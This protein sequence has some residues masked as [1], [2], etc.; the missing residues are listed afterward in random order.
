MR[1]VGHD[2]RD[3]PV[4]GV[5]A[6]HADKVRDNVAAG[7]LP[8]VLASAGVEDWDAE[9]ARGNRDILEIVLEVANGLCKVRAVEGCRDGKEAV[10]EAHLAVGVGNAGLVK[11]SG[12]LEL[13]ELEVETVER[14]GRASDDKVACAVHQGNSDVPVFRQVLVGGVDVLLNGLAGQITEGK[15]RSGST[16]ALVDR[17]LQDIGREGSARV[18]LLA[19]KT[20]PE[21]D[22]ERVSR[23]LVESLK[24]LGSGNGSCGD[25][26]L[27]VT[28]GTREALPDVAG[29][30]AQHSAHDEVVC[31]LGQTNEWETHWG[32][33]QVFGVWLRI[34]VV[35]PAHNIEALGVKLLSLG[36]SRQLL[37]V[38]CG[39]CD[40]VLD[41][42][43]VCGVDLAELIKVLLDVALATEDGVDVGILVGGLAQQSRLVC[44]DRATGC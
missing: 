29:V 1:G 11:T 13:A 33:N 5:L 43:R 7:L 15:H 40:E 31:E 28:G 8:E 26:T 4:D 25:H 24:V 21:E 44:L 32:G 16:L 22:A 17:V 10:H 38:C 39:G 30:G 27:R 41:E 37:Q 36:V 20:N 18:G 6:D 34:L 9:V 35:Q 19:A 42:S 2:S 3:L 14:H 12:S 23:R